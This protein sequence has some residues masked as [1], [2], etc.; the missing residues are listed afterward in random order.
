MGCMINYEVE[1][2]MK[3]LHCADLHLDSI[4]NTYLTPDKAKERKAELLG[5]FRRMVR[6]ASDNNVNAI[7]IAGDLYDKKNISTTA[8]NVVFHEI[9]NHPE[10]VFYYLKGNHDT[11]GFLD[12][13]EFIP[14][15]LKLFGNEWNSY[16]VSEENG[17]K[18]VITGV[19]LNSDNNDI[20]N[21]LVLRREDFNIVVLHGQ[22]A[23]TTSKDKAE[24][25]SLKDLRNKNID[26]LA[27]GHI[28]SYKEEILDSRGIYCYPGC[29]EGRGFDECGE[30]GFVV[31]DID[32]RNNTFK[33]EFIPFAKRNTYSLE[34]NISGCVNSMEI[35]TRISQIIK[36]TSYDSG[37]LIKIILTGEV[38]VECEINEEF[39]RKQ[40]E[41]DFYYVKIKNESRFAI[42]YDDFMYDESLKGEFVR[43]VKADAGL[44]EEEKS[45][46]IRYGILALKGEE[47]Q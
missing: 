14:N 18:I 39:L 32:V 2:N 38:D 29:L 19:E 46:V 11:N 5:T 28:H 41:N 33:R 45:T 31:L 47:L 22:E 30:H 15:N 25:I 9:T 27:L 13:L 44:T 1:K 7:I 12:S 3:I 35:M 20:Y 10:I 42:N 21:S 26:Y 40:F 34:V 16:T 43:T 17:R 6:Y 37:H 8:V 36:E 4:M 23:N 24:I